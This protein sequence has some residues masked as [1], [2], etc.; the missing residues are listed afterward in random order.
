M[1]E[2]YKLLSCNEPQPTFLPKSS[3][4]A[5]LLFLPSLPLSSSA[6][7]GEDSAAQTSAWPRYF[8][9]A[10]A[11]TV[12]VPALQGARGAVRGGTRRTSQALP[13]QR[14][15]FTWVPSG[16]IEERLSDE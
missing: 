5:F 11:V 6:L 13:E 9:E 1:N 2:R 16:L 4:L 10:A 14:L 7:R 8:A 12:V 3:L 15:T